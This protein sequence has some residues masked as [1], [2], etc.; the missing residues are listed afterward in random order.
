MAEVSKSFIVNELSG[1][2]E[3][4]D[5]EFLWDDPLAEYDLSYVVKMGI[6]FKALGELLTNVARTEALKQGY[7]VNG[8]EVIQDVMYQY[9]KGTTY[10]AVDTKYVR[11]QLPEAEYPD[12]WKKS[13]RKE[14]VDMVPV[15]TKKE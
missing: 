14:T 3:P 15:I 10:P 2:I 7:G 5:L 8:K 13:S 12:F 11:E 9:K 6:A 1:W 4:K